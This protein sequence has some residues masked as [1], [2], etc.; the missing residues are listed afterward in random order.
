MYGTHKSV[1]LAECLDWLVGRDQD[2]LILADLTFG[3]G[4]HSCAMA[5]L[6]KCEK[7]YAFDQDPDALAH[8]REKLKTNNLTD[9]VELLDSN[10]VHF[11]QKIASDV[12][13]DGVLLDL[14][15]SS[16]QF[17]TG[18]RG[19]SFRFEGPLDMRM[20][21]RDD[22]VQTASDIIN[23]WEASDLELI[24]REYGEEKYA[25]RIAQKIAEVRAESPIKTTKDL[26][27]IIFHCYPKAERF[28][29]KKPAAKVF[30][31]L[32][33]A[34]NRELEVLEKVVDQIVPRLKM[35]GRLAIISFHSL[36]DRIVKQAF[37][38]YEAHEEFPVVI[39]TKKPVLP[40]ESEILD[41]SRAR[42]AKL[43]VIER[44]AMRRSKNK[45]P[46]RTVKE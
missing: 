20:N 18:E 1:L 36:E 10:F 44:I 4:G 43:R 24:F 15:V 17:D 3:A 40:T 28:A 27:D 45:Y 42:S 11:A 19:F 6:S 30:Q 8:G 13:F 41:N 7:L 37:K 46:S 26:E 34:V 31:A 32:R 38:K 14:G 25:R 9:K 12:L 33:I 35:G 2:G 5:K 29:G 21:P 16:H 39:L 22:H 23:S